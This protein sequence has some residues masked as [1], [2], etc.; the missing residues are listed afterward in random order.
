LLGIRG[1]YLVH[2]IRNG[3]FPILAGE[4][5]FLWCP[6]LLWQEKVS[7][8]MQM[9]SHR[10]IRIFMPLPFIS[11][12]LN[13]YLL[14][15]SINYAHLLIPRQ[16]QTRREAGTESY[17]SPQGGGEDSRVAWN[18]AVR[19]FYWLWQGSRALECAAA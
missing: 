17:G 11:E 6:F 8:Q 18:E 16:S 14:T 4:L 19:F 2:I 15:F 1:W 7:R 9:L 10:G 12:K 13:I 5:E 3:Q